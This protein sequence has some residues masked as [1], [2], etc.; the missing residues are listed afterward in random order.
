MKKRVQVRLSSIGFLSLLFLMV[1]GPVNASSKIVSI[2]A[3]KFSPLF[4]MDKYQNAFSVQA[5]QIDEAP[6]T[7]QEFSE[8]LKKNSEWKKEKVLSLYH[9]EKYLSQWKGGQNTKAKPHSAVVQV[10]W[11]AAQAYCEWKTGRLPTTLEWEYVAAASHDEADASQKAEFNQKILDWYAK[12]QVAAPQ[13]E[14]GK[15]KANFYGVKNLHGLI[16]E[17][18]SDFNTFFVAAD[19]RSDGDKSSDMF[20]G[21]GSIA[22]K[23]RSAYAAFMRYAFRSSLKASYSTDNLGFRCAYDHTQ[24]ENRK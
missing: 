21:A 24:K 8:F 17:W 5:F 4:G 3:G 13:Q 20:C 18:T 19:N 23:D 9:D 16:W 6:V 22:A 14:V 7:V 12:P 10:S 2:P 1:A 11:F 15:D